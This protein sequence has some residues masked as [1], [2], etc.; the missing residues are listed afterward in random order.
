[1]PV[2]AALMAVPVLGE[3]PEPLEILGILAATAG[4]YFVTGARLGSA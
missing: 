4:V 1:V 3:Y 2:L